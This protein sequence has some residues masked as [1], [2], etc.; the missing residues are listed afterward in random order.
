MILV[1]SYLLVV[2]VDKRKIQWLLPQNPYMSHV[3]LISQ[4]ISHTQFLLNSVHPAGINLRFLK[5]NTVNVISFD[6]VFNATDRDIVGNAS[7]I[8]DNEARHL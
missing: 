1:D 3:S 4:A 5:N 7:D 2:T 6:E 8:P